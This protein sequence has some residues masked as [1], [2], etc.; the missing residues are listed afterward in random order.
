V[1]ISYKHLL[2]TEVHK[3]KMKL[4]RLFVSIRLHPVNGSILW[5]KP[6]ISV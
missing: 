4:K 6:N 1:N 3:T 5:R 2:L